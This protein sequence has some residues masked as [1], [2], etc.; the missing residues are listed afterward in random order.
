MQIGTSL[1][2][3]PSKAITQRFHRRQAV[4]NST[5]IHGGEE[6]KKKA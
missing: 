3:T 1:P 4:K 2:L 6:R 5:E